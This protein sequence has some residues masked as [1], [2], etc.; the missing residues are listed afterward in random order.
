ML[1]VIARSFARSRPS[2]INIVTVLPLAIS[3][4]IV[5]SSFWINPEFTSWL[6]VFTLLV[7]SWNEYPLGA[8][9]AALAGMVW[10]VLVLT[11]QT[12]IWVAIP[13]FWSTIGVA[14][15]G[16]PRSLEGHWSLLTA[17][18]RSL[19]A[20]ALGALPGVLGLLTLFGAWRGDYPPSAPPHQGLSPVAPALILLHSLVCSSS[21]DAEARCAHG[22]ISRAAMPSAAGGDANP[23]R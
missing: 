9:E 21:E 16:V 6:F 8:K 11:R 2:W 20:L 4:Y 14:Y 1:H 19:L 15:D 5:S 3:Y 22:C 12:H 18:L 10:S 7:L 13:L 17:R 23:D